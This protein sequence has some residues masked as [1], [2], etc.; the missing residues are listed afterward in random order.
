MPSTV[1]AQATFF[2]VVRR[3]HPSIESKLV[4]RANG[5]QD[6]D[7]R[8]REVLVWH[9]ANLHLKFLGPVFLHVSDGTR[10][11]LAGV[12]RNGGN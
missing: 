3:E 1:P 10:G 5:G 9:A 7:V 6:I 8:S 4:K 2:P 12:A 11:K